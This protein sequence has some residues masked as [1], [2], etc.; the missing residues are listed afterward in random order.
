MQIKSQK[1][2]FSGLMFMG[3]GGAFAW[4]ATTYSLGTA[5][6]MG[7]GYFPLLLGLLMMLLGLLITFK[8]LV[9]ETEDG[10]RMGRWAWRPLLC[11]LV[12]NVAFGL[13]LA[14]LPAIGLPPMGLVVAV[15]VLVF[16]A[17]LAARRCV[18]RSALVVAATLAA[19]SYLVC[20]PLL[21]LQIQV[22]PAF[23]VG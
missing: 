14:G 16:I 23:T 22:W 19:G 1:D 3:L 18:L 9:T 10:G 7:P 12:A 21:K 11:I 15:F 13:L 5:A 2:F 6:R 20:I 17:A 4:G 8:S